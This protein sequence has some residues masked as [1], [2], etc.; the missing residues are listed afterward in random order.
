VS[1]IF[2][3][4]PDLK[5]AKGKVEGAI[6]TYLVATASLGTTIGAQILNEKR[7]ADILEWI[8]SGD[9]EPRHRTFKKKRVLHSGQW[10]LESDEYHKWIRSNESSVLICPGRGI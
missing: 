2:I 1:V 7:N 5:D 10:F 6:H 8:W 3:D 9:F 4:S